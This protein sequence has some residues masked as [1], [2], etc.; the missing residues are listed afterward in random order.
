MQRRQFVDW[1]NKDP[2]DFAEED[3]R[4]YFLYLRET[5]KLAPSSINIV[6]HA[7][8]FF[9]VHTLQRDWLSSTSCAS[10]SRALQ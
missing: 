2:G 6:V 3:V 7:L 1:T 5:K 8:R 9:L 10:T 4:R